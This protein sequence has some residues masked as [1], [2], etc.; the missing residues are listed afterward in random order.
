MA[1]CS[2]DDKQ[3]I[4]NEIMNYLFNFQITN[5]LYHLH[6]TSFARHKASDEF[7]G[8]LLEHIDKF[9]EVFIGRY[10][11]KPIIDRVKI[12]GE[13]LSDDAM[14]NKYQELRAYLGSYDSMFTNDKDILNIRDD[15]VA[16][17]NKTLYLFDLS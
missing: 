3:C 14:V 6:T 15:L 12:N 9:A 17:I 2:S 13:Y 5:K 8:T 7:D 11:K 16:S 10:K 4:V 1:T